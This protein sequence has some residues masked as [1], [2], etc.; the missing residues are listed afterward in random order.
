VRRECGIMKL[1]KHDNIS[2]PHHVM[3]DALYTPRTEY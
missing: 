3:D 1:S 2:E